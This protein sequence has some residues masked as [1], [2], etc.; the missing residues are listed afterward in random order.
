MNSQ[1]IINS[2]FK[3]GRIVRLGFG[4]V[5]V[6]MIGVGVSS[7]LAM[8]RI[9]ESNGWVEHTHTVISDIRLLEK[10][11]VDAETGQ[12]GYLFTDDEQF[13]EP[14]NAAV[15]NLD[16]TFD[17]L[18]SLT[19]DNPE[20]QNRLAQVDELID[21]KLA[22]LATTIELKRSDQD[23]ALMA[24]VQSGRGKD[25]MDDIRSLTS[26][27]EAT[28]AA[29]LAERDQDVVHA[30]QLADSIALGGTL[31]AVGLGTLAL[32]VIS[33]RV[34]FPIHQVAET[35]SSSSSEMTS[36][37]QEQESSAQ[38]QA[39][40]VQETSTTM[41]EL[42]VA[43]LQSSEHADLAAASAEQVKELANSGTQV[44]NSTI[45]DMDS[46]CQKVEVI[47]AQIQLLNEQAQQIAGITNVVS[48]LANQTNMLALNAAVEAVRAGEHG[49][50]FAVVAG[51]IRKLADQSKGSA[52][53]IQSLVGSIQSAVDKVATSANDGR[54]T[55]EQGS[56]MVQQTADTFMQ[57]VAAIDDISN[58][59]RQISM[60]AK[61][62]VN[63]IQQVVD[64]MT[65]LNHEAVR[66]ASSI[67]QTR[68]NAQQLNEAVR[69]LQVV[70]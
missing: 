18:V 27:M 60:N 29:L 59:S 65:S 17:H 6:V 13:L 8:N 28:E 1:S 50:G 12:R 11:L 42:K 69:K 10:H 44:V 4:T 34:I 21:D 38:Q 30:V 32:V 43:S 62:Q 48:D 15:A 51:E 52:D 54:S 3:L 53:Q 55:V 23:A 68:A 16:E 47:V 24:L 58:S 7:K 45:Q 41:D 33:R 31:L 46:I 19:A 70:V 63:A 49:K 26:Q 9:V 5:V 56:G 37:V 36:T 22:E 20:Q 40:A 14:Y 35:L 39:S 67:S 2:R 25:I 57:V 61:Q 66:G 64:A